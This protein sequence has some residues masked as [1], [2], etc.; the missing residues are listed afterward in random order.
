[1]TDIEQLVERMES[2]AK[3]ANPTAWKPLNPPGEG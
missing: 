2:A 3:A 1:M